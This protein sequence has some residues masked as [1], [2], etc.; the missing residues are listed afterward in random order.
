MVG[1]ENNTQPIVIPLEIVTTA[2]LV[3]CL[4]QLFLVRVSL[5]K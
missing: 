3:A 5:C 2:L 4:V 1:E